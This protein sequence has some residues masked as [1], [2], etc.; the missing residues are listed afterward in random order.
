MSDHV[1]P[2]LLAAL[3]LSKLAVEKLTITLE[4]D[5][6]VRLTIQATADRAMIERFTAEITKLG[7]AIDEQ[8][9]LSLQDIGREFFLLRKDDLQD[10]D[11]GDGG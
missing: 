2:D 3:G 5:Q 11:E 1:G 10:S 4:S 7:V 8:D 9:A 6:P